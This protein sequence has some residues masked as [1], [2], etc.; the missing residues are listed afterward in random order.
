M[1]REEMI[2]GIEEGKDPLELSIQKWQD[3]LDG[4]G[5]QEGSDNCAL[6]Y[7][8]NKFD[9]WHSYGT[10]YNKYACRKCPVYLKTGQQF[11]VGTPYL[12]RPY[13]EVEFLKSLRNS[14]V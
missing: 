4:K 6:C 9:K 7:C 12:F 5:K 14:P 1:N 13:E 2:K 11:C 3:I 8:Y 10:R